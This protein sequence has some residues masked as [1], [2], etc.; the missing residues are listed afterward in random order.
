MAERDNNWFA[1]NNSHFHSDRLKIEL[2]F[3]SWIN[4]EEI[5]I[6]TR[7]VEAL[8]QL[9]GISRTRVVGYHERDA[10]A[11]EVQIVGINSAGSALAGKSGLRKIELYRTEADER[12]GQYHTLHNSDWM[13][14]RLK[15]NM[16]AV[17]RKIIGNGANLKET[18]TW[19]SEIDGILKTAIRNE[20]KK[21]LFALESNVQK[22]FTIYINA[23]SNYLSYTHVYIS[24]I[25]RGTE[26]QTSDLGGLASQVAMN[27]ALWTF[28]QSA[29]NGFEQGGK[30]YRISMLPGFEIDRAM[31]LQVLSRRM[32]VVKKEETS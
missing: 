15:V 22:I 17:G 31:V 29:F 19:A 30:G 27:F 16:D 5:R 9:G 8:M 24:I 2:P 20:G 10:G 3:P 25:S 23:I 28:M 12:S 26:A 1:L 32:K 11:S 7:R 21:H 14:L 4:E 6:N 13:N 18:G